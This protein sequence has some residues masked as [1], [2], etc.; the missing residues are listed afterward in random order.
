MSK[1]KISETFYSIQGEGLWTGVPSVFLRTFGCN[2]TCGGFGLP[3]GELSTER[4]KVATIH[5]SIPFSTYEELPLVKTGCDSYASWDVRFKD[6]SPLLTVDA[7]VERML[8]LLPNNRWTQ[9]NGQDVHLVITGGEPLLGWQR[10]YVELLEH[11]GMRDLKNLTFETN[12]TQK[13]ETRLADYIFDKQELTVT[14]SCS[15]KLSVSG[16]A[17]ENA[18][19]PDIVKSYSDLATTSNGNLY[20]KFVVANSDDMDDVER[21]V[22]EYQKAGVNCPVYLMPVGGTVESY[23]MNNR[24]VAQYAMQQGW[25]YSPRLQ[26]DLFGNAWGT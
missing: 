5:K 1:I 11:E 22:A 23:E 19:R 4:D 14:W 2:F 12:A 16:E 9:P 7:I 15:P 10:S 18:I 13:I 17:W 26:V 8:S 24:Q 21:A 3:K 25:R 20:L 6:L